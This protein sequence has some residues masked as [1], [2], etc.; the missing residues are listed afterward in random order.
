MS[1]QGE[2]SVS[3]SGRSAVWKMSRAHSICIHVVPHLGGVEITMSSGRNGKPSQRAL[4][5]TSERYR[6]TAVVKHEI[7]GAVAL[8]PH[9]RG[10][11][12]VGAGQEGDDREA[13]RQ[14]GD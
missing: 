8:L 10:G 1:S 12:H 7:R 5:A 13:R 2:S 9:G 3:R 6:V 11:G 4:S 14:P